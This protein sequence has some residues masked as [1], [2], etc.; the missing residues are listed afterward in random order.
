MPEAGIAR[1]KFES[2]TDMTPCNFVDICVTYL[3]TLAVYQIIQRPLQHSCRK[4]QWKDVT[5]K[6]L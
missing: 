5:S 2:F 4:M 1:N 6:R 3:I